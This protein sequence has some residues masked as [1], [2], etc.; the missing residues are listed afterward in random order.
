MLPFITSLVNWLFEIGTEKKTFIIGSGAQIK[1]DSSPG[2][3]L[4]DI[5]THKQICSRHNNTMEYVCVYFSTD[6]GKSPRER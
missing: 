3:V 2:T 4:L 6:C 5:A 1:Q